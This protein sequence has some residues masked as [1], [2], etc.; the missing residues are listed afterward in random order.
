MTS[1]VPADRDFGVHVLG[2]VSSPG[3]YP[4]EEAS[5]L[6]TVIIQAG[7][8]ADNAAL[9]NVRWVH[10]SRSGEVQ[11]RR[12]D[13]RGYLR[14]G[15]P[16]GNPLVYPGDTLF[17]EQAKGKVNIVQALTLSTGLAALL[18]NIIK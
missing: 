13:V 15:Q 3:L 4:V 12:I 14:N 1:I 5:P 17:V 7:G 10:E 8:F 2:A 6:M 11:A 9:E 16:S 18:L